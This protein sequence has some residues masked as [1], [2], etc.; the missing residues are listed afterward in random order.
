M[1]KRLQGIIAVFE[2]GN[3]I[4]TLYK[5]YLKKIPS[6]EMVDS[7]STGHIKNKVIK[8]SRKSIIKYGEVIGTIK[9]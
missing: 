9:L 4:Y 5:I 7:V 2:I 1:L 3:G 8:I 6:S